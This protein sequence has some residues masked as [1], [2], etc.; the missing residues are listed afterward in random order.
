MVSALCRSLDV[1]HSTLKV[2]WKRKPVTALQERARIERYRLLARWA[3]ERDLPAVA[4]A[5]HLDDQVETL[6]MRLTRGAG[7]QGL[8][9]MRPIAPFPKPGSSLRLVRPLLGWRRRDL[10]QLCEDTGVKPVEDPS[11]EDPRFERVRVRRG[12][13][14]ATWLDP[15]GIARSAAHLAAAEIAIHWAV[16]REWESQVTGSAREIV[17]RPSAPPGIRRHIVL[18]AVNSLA[19]EGQ[20]NVLRGREIDQLLVL[21]AKGGKATLRGVLCCGGEEW[22][23]SAAPR[24]NH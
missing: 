14:E 1:P 7:V 18:R 11:N 23:F 24:R 6:L 8:A 15:E 13:A 17:Y 19:R 2:A 16:D 20:G 3:E 4:T 9:G 5:H 21:L 22:R 12:L 10:V